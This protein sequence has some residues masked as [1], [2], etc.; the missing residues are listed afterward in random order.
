MN[1]GFKIF[2]ES[3]LKPWF[4]SRWRE[5]RAVYV[6]SGRRRINGYERMGRVV[7]G[8]ALAVFWIGMCL[9]V[10]IWV[11]GFCWGM[12]MAAHSFLLALRG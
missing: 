11:A 1:L 10:G 9:F 12:V 6:G 5:I 8:T 2:Y 3:D 7:S 4:R